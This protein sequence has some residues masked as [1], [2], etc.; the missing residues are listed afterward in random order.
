[1]KRTLQITL[2]LLTFSL[3]IG[4]DFISNTFELKDKS[5]AF[6]EALV[7]EDYS[8]LTELMAMDPKIEQEAKLD[9][10]KHGLSHISKL[11]VK[12][13][14]KDLEY[15]FVVAEKKF[16]TVEANNTPPNTTVVTMEFHNQ[17]EFGVIEILFDDLTKKITYFTIKDVKEPVP[18]M[19]YYWLFGLLAIAV[20]IFNVYVI[21]RIKRSDL[22]KK[23]LKYLAVICLNVPSIIYS[24]VGGL[25]FKLFYFQFFLGIGF[26][27]AGYLNSYWVFGIPLGGLY[28]LW[29][30]KQRKDQIELDL[31]RASLT[32]K[33]AVENEKTT[34]LN[35]T[36]EE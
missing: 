23:W 15:N 8:A 28:C 17:K 21:V 24:A 33:Y 2:S 1:M 35:Q 9:T 26:N 4:C 3:L 10:L 27:T 20:L 16:S 18:N 11:V 6:L 13:F 22:K 30:L 34:L 19:L 32:Q 25:S 7:K 5:K 29:M 14:G 12:N 31:K 36:T